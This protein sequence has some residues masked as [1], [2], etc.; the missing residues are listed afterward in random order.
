MPRPTIC[1]AVK[2]TLGKWI[3]GHVGIRVQAGIEPDGVRF[4]VA[5]DAWIEVTEII[6]E[7]T[8]LGIRVLAGEAK[9]VAERPQAVRIAIR[10]IVP[11]RLGVTPLPDLE[12]VGRSG[13]DS[14]RAQMIGITVS[15]DTLVP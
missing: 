7:E 8:G 1:Q 12:V 10:L 2:I 3:V 15:P 5:S 13:D 11:K 6:V 14:G 9:V 4:D